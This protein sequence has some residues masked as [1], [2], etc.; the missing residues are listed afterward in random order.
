MKDVVPLAMA[1]MAI[2][3]GDD[4]ILKDFVSE[5]GKSKNKRLSLQS[6]ENDTLTV[7]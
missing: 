3:Y 7:D 1:S 4:D 6:I 2:L 5:G